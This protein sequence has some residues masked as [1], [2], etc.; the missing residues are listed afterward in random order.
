MQVGRIFEKTIH[1][2]AIRF[3]AVILCLVTSSVG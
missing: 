2:E 1:F 3:R